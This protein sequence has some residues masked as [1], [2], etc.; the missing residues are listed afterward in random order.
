M[1][2]Y[3]KDFKDPKDFRD[4]K[5]FYFSVSMIIVEH[6]IPVLP[7]RFVAVAAYSLGHGMGTWNCSSASGEVA[8]PPGSVWLPALMDVTPRRII[9]SRKRGL[10]R[11][12]YEISTSWSKMRKAIVN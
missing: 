2:I 1:M 5:D 4:P 11:V 3:I 7:H 8:Y 6:G 10:S 9:L 12:E